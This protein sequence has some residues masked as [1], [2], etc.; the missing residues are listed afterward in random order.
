VLS[1][2]RESSLQDAAHALGVLSATPGPAGVC[3][4]Q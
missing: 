3:P 2:A 4:R 1:A